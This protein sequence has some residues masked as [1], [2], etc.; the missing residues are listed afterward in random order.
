MQTEYL[1]QA[2][3]LATE[4]SRSGLGGPYGAVIVRGDQVIVSSA[5]LVTKKNDPTATC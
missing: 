1:Q 5:N 2:I 3:D 4:N